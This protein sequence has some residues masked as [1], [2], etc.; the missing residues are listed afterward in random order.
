MTAV[1]VTSQKETWFRSVARSRAL[2]YLPVTAFVLDLV[3]ISF[4]TLLAGLIRE[5]WEFFETQ[6]EVLGVE[7]TDAEL[8]QIE[9]DE[10]GEPMTVAA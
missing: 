7:P 6:A 3:V 5:R 4:S 1:S 9:L 10:A 8:A 2:R